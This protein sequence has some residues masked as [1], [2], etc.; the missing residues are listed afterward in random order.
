[1]KDCYYF[2]Q[3]GDYMDVCIII[4]DVYNPDDNVAMFII[5]LTFG[6]LVLLKYK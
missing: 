3:K 6:I 2:F 1:M 4:S 5:E